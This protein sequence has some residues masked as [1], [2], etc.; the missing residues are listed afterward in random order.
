MSLNHA[1]QFK[2]DS[3]TCPT[4]ERTATGWYGP[5]MGSCVGGDCSVVPLLTSKLQFPELASCWAHCEAGPCSRPS[6]C[7]VT[8]N[9]HLLLTTS[10]HRFMYLRSGWGSTQTL[11]LKKSTYICMNA[12][13]NIHC[14]PEHSCRPNTHSTCTC[15]HVHI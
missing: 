11:K 4:P 7:M 9:N 1:T 12:S 8:F 5:R 13:Y 3:A 2:H 6:Y 10:M 15:L 14:V